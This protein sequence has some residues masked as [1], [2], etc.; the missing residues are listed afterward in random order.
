MLKI[1]SSI[2]IYIYIYICIYICIY[3]Y[4][5][6]YPSIYILMYLPYYGNTCLHWPELEATSNF[7]RCVPCHLATWKGSSPIGPKVAALLTGHL[8]GPM[9]SSPST[10]CRGWGGCCGS[11]TARGGGKGGGIQDPGRGGGATNSATTEGVGE[12]I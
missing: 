3:I 4:I 8:M 10:N 9:P 6:T 5:Y 11:T 1:K 7:G 2:Y 12:K